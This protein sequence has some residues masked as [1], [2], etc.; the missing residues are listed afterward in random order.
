MRR[1]A[2]VGSVVL[3]VLSCLSCKS[4]PDP[5]VVRV[6]GPLG[7]TPF[8]AVSNVEL[9]VRDEAGAERMQLRLSGRETSFEVPESAKSGVG[10]L[11]LVGLGSDGL[12]AEYGRTPNLDLSGL[13]GRAIVNLTIVVQ[14]TR[15]IADAYTLQAPNPAPRCADVGAR[16]AFIADATAKYAD[17]IDLLDHTV[18]REEAFDLEPATLATAGPRTLVIDQAGAGYV[19]DV[20]N[21]TSTKLTDS[22]AGV[23]G[24]AVIHDDVGGVWIVGATRKASPSDDVLRLDAGGTFAKRKLLAP[25]SN[26]AATWVAGRGLVVAY[27]GGGVEILAPGAATGAATPFP[28]DAR[29]GGVIAPIDNNRLLRIDEDGVGTVLDLTCAKECM[30]TTSMLNDDKRAPRA[31]DHVTLLEG[32][33]S[34]IVRGGRVL[35][36]EKEKLTPLHDARDKAVCSAA[37]GDGTAM[38]MVAG[39]PIVRSVAPGR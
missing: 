22:L 23:A 20:D 9:R 4:D 6:R 5:F 39:D 12:V 1:V 38:V 24:G 32:G 37:I 31:D 25:R 26:A 21:D 17:V 36:L 15:T 16:Y 33:S 28:T 34:L 11:A 10:S 18:R 19:L 3:S 2:L 35:L 8:S 29:A 27:G 13:T 14:K 30:P 7:A